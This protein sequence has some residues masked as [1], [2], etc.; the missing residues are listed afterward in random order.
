[1]SLS[2]LMVSV[3]QEIG[4]VITSQIVTTTAMK[5][6]PYVSQC[7][8]VMS[9]FDAERVILSTVLHKPRYPGRALCPDPPKL[10]LLLNATWSVY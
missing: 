5:Q 9:F 1:M 7:E 4:N 10:A 3:S 6:I 2:V 8:H